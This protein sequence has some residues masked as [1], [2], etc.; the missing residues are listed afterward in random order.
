MVYYVQKS[1][2]FKVSLVVRN[3]EEIFQHDVRMTSC[4][5][6]KVQCDIFANEEVEPNQDPWEVGT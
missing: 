3:W 1:G 5:S 6:K 2:G 4:Y